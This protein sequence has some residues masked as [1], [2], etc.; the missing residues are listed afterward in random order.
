MVYSAVTQLQMNDE[1]TGAGSDFRL[2]ILT[3]ILIEAFEFSEF[4][5]RQRTVYETE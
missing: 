1:T 2:R 4:K 5:L 3:K